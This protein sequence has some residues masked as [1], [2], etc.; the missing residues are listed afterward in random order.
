MT[1]LPPIKRRRIPSDPAA[2]Q[3]Q[4]PGQLARG[5]PSEYRAIGHRE[6]ERQVLHREQRFH[7]SCGHWISV[8]SWGCR[9]RIELRSG[10][11][12]APPAAKALAFLPLGSN[13][14]GVL[15]LVRWS[16]VFRPGGARP[17]RQRH[18]QARRAIAEATGKGAGRNRST[19]RRPERRPSRRIDMNVGTRPAET[20]T[21][22]A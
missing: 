7:S 12:R 8:V 15:F 4:R 5:R 17:N 10:P 2:P 13:P 9:R 6:Q 14:W 18:S 19:Q 3:A 22:V 20:Q 1:T 16:T 21:R 11:T